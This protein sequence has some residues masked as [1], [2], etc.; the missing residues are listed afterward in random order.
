MCI[1]FHEHCKKEEEMLLEINYQYFKIH[2]TEHAK[3]YLELSKLKEDVKQK[4]ISQSGIMTSLQ[5]CLVDHIDWQDMQYVKS[6]KD[7]KNR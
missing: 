5:K 6:Y 1:K 3:L 7:W 4:K 2:F